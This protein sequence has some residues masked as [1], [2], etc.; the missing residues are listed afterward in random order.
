MKKEPAK[1]WRQVAVFL[2]HQPFMEDWA[3]LGA[4]IVKNLPA[5]QETWVWFLGQEDAL[6]KGMATQSSILA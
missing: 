4:Q 5:G 3:S 2:A 1:A 6:E